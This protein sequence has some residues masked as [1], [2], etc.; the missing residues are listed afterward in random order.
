MGKRLVFLI[1]FVFVSSSAVADDLLRINADIRYRWE[2][3]N[4]FNQ[5]FYGKNPPKGDSNDGFL[6]QRIRL[7]FDFNPHRNVHI[8]AGLQDSRAYDVAL[9]DDAFYKSRLGLEHNP[10]KDYWEPFD[11]YLELKNLFGKKTQS[12]RWQADNCLW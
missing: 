3:E 7:T 12:E 8:S 10:N 1:L 6:L 9:P 4:S 5:K 2:Y 11:T